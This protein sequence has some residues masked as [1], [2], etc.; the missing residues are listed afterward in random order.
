MVGAAC[1]VA[2]TQIKTPLGERAIE[3]LVIGDVVTTDGADEAICWIGRLRCTEWLLAAQR[4]LAPVCIHA[5]ALAPG[6]PRRNLLVSPMHVMLSE[7][8]L[9]PAAQ[10]VNGKSVVRHHGPGP[11]D[12]IHIELASQGLIWAEDVASQTFRSAHSRGVFDNAVEYAALYPHAR[13][14]SASSMPRTDGHAVDRLRRRL[15]QRCSA[16]V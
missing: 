12:Y 15:A 1:F 9:A 5:G 2:G 4:H 6:V 16:V 8:V 11:V 14:T 13:Q 3:T 10:L 7:G